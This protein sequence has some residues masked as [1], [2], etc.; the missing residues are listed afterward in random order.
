MVLA[1]P[2]SYMNL[3]GAAVR[4]LMREERCD[5]SCLVVAHDDLDLT[6]GRLKFKLKGG[7]GGH[8]GVR[9][10][11]EVLGSDRFMRMRIGIG[12]PPAGMEATDYVLE[13]FGEEEW[14]VMEGALERA[15][16][17]LRVLTQRGAQEAMRLFHTPSHCQA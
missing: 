2:R 1:K 6:L 11:M 7:D 13:P 16:E 4:A 8:R 12:R 15:V 17:G 9:S 5:P 14:A 10:I 3:S